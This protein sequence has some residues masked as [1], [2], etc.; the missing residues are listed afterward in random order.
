MSLK[1]L[2]HLCF[3]TE[4]SG[5]WMEPNRLG[6]GQCDRG[7]LTSPELRI[8]ACGIHE[9]SRS[10]IPTCGG[11]ESLSCQLLEQISEAIPERSLNSPVN[12]ISDDFI[13]RFP[14]MMRDIKIL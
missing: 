11:E 12:S 7:P 14:H 4:Y 9:L 6:A 2:E 8:A 5:W 3:K 13:H 10:W 1:S